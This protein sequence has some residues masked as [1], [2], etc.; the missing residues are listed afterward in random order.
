MKTRDDLRG[1]A[2]DRFKGD[3]I[4]MIQREFASMSDVRSGRREASEVPFVGE[5]NRDHVERVVAN[6]RENTFNRSD[7]NDL[8]KFRQ[9]LKDSARDEG[10]AREL[11]DYRQFELTADVMASPFALAAFQE[12]PLSATELPMIVRPRSRNSQRFTV[13]RASVD[14]GQYSA[15]WQTTKSAETAEMDLLSTDKVEYSL[16]DI[17]QGN[18][19]EFDNINV[20]LTYDMEMKIDGLAKT[21]IDA[22]Q[23]ASGLRDNLSIHPL[24]QVDTIPDTN[25]LDLDTLY[26]GDPDVLT[27]EKLKYILNHV[28]LL[29]AAFQKEGLKM[30]SIQMSPLN[31]RDA[32]DFTDLVYDAT[33]S[34]IAPKQTVTTPVREQIFSTGAITNAWGMTFSWVPNTQIPKGKMYVFFNQPLGWMFTKTEFDKLFKWDE[35]NSMD[36]AEANIGEIM[37]RRCLAFYM[38][39]LWKYRILIIDL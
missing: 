6:R 20:E 37:W 19:S 22:Q 21:N 3:S 35:S 1:S 16:V 24:V 2:D 29:E 28:A 30:Q 34:E 23:T 4:N 33:G 13:R 32:W 15:Q 14:G 9:L 12:V 25:Y 26:P 38:P 36:H 7:K 5:F 11:A 8:K 27:I 17:Q 31:L 10:V 39:D 18:V